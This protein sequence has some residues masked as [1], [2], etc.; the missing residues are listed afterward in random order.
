MDLQNVD[1]TGG[2]RTV[3][4]VERE[5]LT[6]LSCSLP[7]GTAD[8]RRTSTAQMFAKAIRCDWTNDGARVLFHGSTEMSREVMEFVLEERICCAELTYHIATMPPHDHIALFLRGPGN[9][10]DAIRAWVGP[11]R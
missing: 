3:R 1:A 7:A 10:R 5:V 2:A 4:P 8:T 9:L 6:A 11:E